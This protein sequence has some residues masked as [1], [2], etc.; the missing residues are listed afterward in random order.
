MTRANRLAEIA[1]KVFEKKAEKVLALKKK[2]IKQAIAKAYKAAGKGKYHL[3]IKYPKSFNQSVR[4]DIEGEF[5]KMGFTIKIKFKYP[6]KH[7]VTLYWN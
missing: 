3:E 5:I 6:N 2:F 4:Y 1:D 7:F